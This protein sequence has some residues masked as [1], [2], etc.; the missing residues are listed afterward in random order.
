V[1]PKT[2]KKG[3]GGN[4][5]GGR[6]IC[7]GVFP[8]LLSLWGLNERMLFCRKDILSEKISR[9]ER[10]PAGETRHAGEWVPLLLECAPAEAD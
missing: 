5:C 9:E 2:R 8:V 6:H 1:A 7:F 3:L 4:P 10:M